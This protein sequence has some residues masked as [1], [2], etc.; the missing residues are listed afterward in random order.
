MHGMINDQ[1][2]GTCSG[3][4][5]TLADE[6]KVTSDTLLVMQG[7]FSSVEKTVE[8]MDATLTKFFDGRGGFNVWRSRID[9]DYNARK[10]TRESVKSKMI[11]TLAGAFTLAIIAGLILLLGAQ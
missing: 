7:Q 11:A 5:K 2:Q 8:K 9:D 3:R 4:F 6:Q 10:R 1:Y